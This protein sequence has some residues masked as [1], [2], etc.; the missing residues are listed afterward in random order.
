MSTVGRSAVAA[1]LLVSCSGSGIDEPGSSTSQKS[2]A[3]RVYVGTMSGPD[4]DASVALALDG[5]L[6]AAYV[7]GDHPTLEPYT[8]WFTGVASNLS[9]IRL[10]RDGSSLFA[11]TTADHAAGTFVEPDGTSLAWTAE[12][13]TQS[14][15]SGLYAA[16]GGACTTG[17]IVI[18]DAAATPLVR[19][20][21]CSPE[22]LVLQVTPI[23]PVQ[24]VDGRLLIEIVDADS[25]QRLAIPPVELPLPTP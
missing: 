23:Y 24:F 14:A 21:T 12:F 8:G 5:N 2:V 9:D 6:V 4:G 11:S 10:Q 17:A 18:D 15:A 16:A 3:P 19:G 22:G 20:S 7:C 13:V 1:I 25:V